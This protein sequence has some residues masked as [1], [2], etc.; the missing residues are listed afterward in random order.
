MKV[1]YNWLKE[2]V[3][4]LPLP[5]RLAE[6]LTMAGFEVEGMEVLGKG[7]TGVVVGKILSMEKHPNADRLTLCKVKTDRVHSIVCGAKNMKE[8]DKVALAL[9]GAT[10]P[11]NVKIE[12]TRIRGVESEGMMCS[13][14]ELGLKDAAEGIMILP[15]SLS[16]GKDITE[17]LNIKDFIFDIN[18]T[19]NRPDCLSILGI[20]RE[21]AAITGSAIRSQE[22]KEVKKLRRLEGKKTSTSQLLN[23]PSSQLPT[24]SIK[25]PSLCR[26]YAARVVENIK[27]GPSPD[28]LKR[29]LES[30]GFRSIN[31]VVD[32]TNYLMI[33]YGQPLHAFD[34]DLVSGRQ[35][36]VRRAHENEKIQ[37]LDGVERVLREYMLVI[38]DSSRPIAMA[39]IMGGKESEIRDSTKNILFESAYFDPSCVRM[40]SKSLGVSTESSY[41][42]ERGADIEVVAKVLDK[43]ARMIAEL[44]GGN[45]ADGIIDK[46]PR[47]FKPVAISV[48]LARIN[49]LLGVRIEKK[50]VEDCLKRLGIAFKPAGKGRAAKGSDGHTWTVTPPSYRVDL[51]KEIDIIEEVARIY[52]YENIPTTL[53]DAG[54]S[55]AKIA[56]TGLLR[57]KMRNILTNNGFL[58][59]VNYSFISPL[60]FEIT[61]PDIKQGLRLL[62][63]LT[64]EQSIMRQSLIPGLLGTLQYNL[65]HNNRNIKIFEIGRI[66]IPVDKKIEEKELIAGLMSGLRYDEAWNNRRETVDFFDIKGALEQLLAGLAIDMCAFIPKAD[67]PFLHPGK[68]CVVE[69][70]GS[71]VGIA[72]EIHPDIV[73][74]LDMK[75]TTYIFELYMD[76][77]ALFMDAK[78]RYA[79][80]PKYPVTARDAAMIVGEEIP[81][82][83]LFDT[84]KG[85][86]VNLLEEVN[87]FDVY[88]GGNIPEGKRSIAV[89]LMYRSPDRT[90]TDEEVNVAH[91][92]IL[93]KLKDRF[94]IEVRGE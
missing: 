85:L 62:N 12:K 15:Q 69:K 22:T 13:E 86:G 77:I 4:A 60:T 21:V 14:A 92:A 75:Q 50:A 11:N 10:L 27:V 55:A 38:A 53:P 2:Y 82:Q 73:Q 40:A 89:R 5:D 3:K 71:R 74:R 67:I 66:F 56:G 18:V 76:S 23:L 88:Y 68:T 25:E 91:A 32:V 37:T 8:G 34:Y 59:V 47:P 28:W 30:I 19:P 52:G 49:K 41:R 63:P 48:R 65:H 46:Y 6:K 26:R 61:V 84:I 80:I 83:E 29:R 24:V 16:L 57:E 36:I 42:F 78:K 58:E 93:S 54:L 35:V 70:D 90:L 45:I 20:A 1:S 81:V 43:A 44:A 87:V 64:E 33:E 39:G 72:G 51:L 7:I 31:N 94:G 17:A 79:P 9:P